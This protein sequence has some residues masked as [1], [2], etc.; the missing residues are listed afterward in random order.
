MKSYG[1]KNNIEIF[2]IPEK[3]NE[4]LRSVF[5]EICDLIDLPISEGD[6]KTISISG[7]SVTL[8]LSKK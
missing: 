6:V 3:E 5:N 2:N 7:L 1:I 8:Q 4:D